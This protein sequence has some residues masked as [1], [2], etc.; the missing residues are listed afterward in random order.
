MRKDVGLPFAQAIETFSK[1][2]P[3]GLPSRSLLFLPLSSYGYHQDKESLFLDF[4]PA[5]CGEPSTR[6][7]VIE[8]QALGIPPQ[9][10]PYL[11]SF[12][13]TSQVALLM[14][15]FSCCSGHLLATGAAGPQ[16]KGPAGSWGKLCLCLEQVEARPA[17]VL[18]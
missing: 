16:D 11:P 13:S 6:A 18:G 4:A 7:Q 8:G 2:Y 9:I 17:G 3:Q 14:T 12:P 10:N 15:A 5:E 1:R